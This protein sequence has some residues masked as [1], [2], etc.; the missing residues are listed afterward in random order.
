MTVDTP[1]PQL[2]VPRDL[3]D[4]FGPV[5]L[6]L[7]NQI[8][9]T[10]G[11]R[12]EPDPKAGPDD[13]GYKTDLISRT[14]YFNPH[15]V[16]KLPAF[17][18]L[19]FFLHELGHHWPPVTAFQDA[20]VRLMP[21]AEQ[22]LPADMAHKR[23]FLHSIENTLADLL[24][25]SAI[26]QGTQVVTQQL[27]SSCFTQNRGITFLEGKNVPNSQERLQQ[28]EKDDRKIFPW[29]R[30]EFQ[31]PAY[32]QFSNLPLV[33]PFFSNGLPPPDFV[34][35]SVA[36]RYPM[37]T[38]LFAQMMNP[39]IAGDQKA[40]LFIDFVKELAP[41]IEERLEQIRN[42]EGSIADAFGEFEDEVGDLIVALDR[43]SAPG[44][45]V[46]GSGENARIITSGSLSAEQ[47]KALQVLMGRT[48]GIQD[49]EL[50]REA[51]RMGM[52]LDLYK[53]F[54][55]T[56][57]QY[58]G[59]I[60]SL[61]ETLTKFVLR[62]YRK[63]FIRHQPTGF[64][65]TPGRE[66]ETYRRLRAGETRPR[67]M[68]DRRHVL[69]PKSLQLWQLVDT[70][71]SMWGDIEGTLG[72]YTIVTRAAFNIHEELHK[73]PAKYDLRRVQSAPLEFGATGFDSYPY[74]LIPL[75]PAVSLR[76]LGQAYSHIYERTQIGGSTSDERALRY[77]HER[78]RV[79]SPQ[80]LK[81][82]SMLT[83]GA[84]QGD[85]LEPILRQI[86]EDKSIHF[87]VNG[88]G[89]QGSSVE[90]FYL[91]KFRP[92]HFYHVFAASSR[93]V[94]QA[95]PKTIAFYEQSIRHFFGET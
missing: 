53:R 46:A 24:L 83:D 86:E 89:D 74:P 22:L 39:T 56:C 42:T 43:V 47:R 1:D 50:Q 41:L 26:P 77:Q 3:T 21:I 31:V 2:A 32:A 52:T 94:E 55:Q 12:I 69:N 93:T 78:M 91:K 60:R 30:E 70:S 85:Q 84:G 71:S 68:I 37:L 81:I 25:E 29:D 19:A 57:E 62:E 6:Q 14:I 79:G 48:A 33:A 88:V 51:D 28:F 54:L 73:N 20:C 9:D 44:Q 64:M 87:L 10:V 58:D 7:L 45:T 8:A 75:T 66:V 49:S 59:Y 72:Y 76:A 61:T 92:A 23:K 95:I 11:F 34:A 36:S 40:P 27:F 80:T 63:D 90:Q 15:T 17:R 13:V 35:P 5:E 82:L 67:T 38:H 16:W 18:R 4:L 65:V